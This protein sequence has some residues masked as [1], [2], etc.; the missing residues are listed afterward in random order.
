MNAITNKPFIVPS[1]GIA[2]IDPCDMDDENF[3]DWLECIP[4]EM[5]EEW[6]ARRKYQF[7]K[8][9]TPAPDAVL[10]DW[11]FLSFVVEISNEETGERYSSF[12]IF[13]NEKP[14]GK[15]GKFELLKFALNIPAPIETAE[16]IQC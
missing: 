5:R 2:N 13:G 15:K 7:P 14:K 16:A 8:P 12:E 6:T 11:R 1:C 9:A 4:E 3:N 10:N